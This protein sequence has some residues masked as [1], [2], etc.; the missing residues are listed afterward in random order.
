MR[1]KRDRRGHAVLLAGAAVRP[2][3]EDNL[4][5]AAAVIL[6]VVI[7]AISVS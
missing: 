3:R 6:S 5:V 1:R 4:A 2:V 7:V